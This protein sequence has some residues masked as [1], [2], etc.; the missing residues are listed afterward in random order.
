MLDCIQETLNPAG[1]AV[2]IEL[3][4]LCMQMRAVSN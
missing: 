3:Q 1:V 2:E 4:H